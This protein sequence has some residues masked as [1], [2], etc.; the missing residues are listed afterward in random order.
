M[1]LFFTLVFITIVAVGLFAATYALHARA[2]AAAEDEATVERTLTTSE[3]EA[4]IQ[5]RIAEAQQPL[6]DQIETLEGK[7]RDTPEADE[8]TSPPRRRP[9][10]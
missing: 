3:F 1:L 9:I 10:R 6:L 7:L 2:K 5:E 8:D 4:I